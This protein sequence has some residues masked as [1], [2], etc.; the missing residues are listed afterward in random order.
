MNTKRRSFSLLLVV[1]LLLTSVV[2]ANAQGDGLTASVA[3]YL[4][5]R[6]LPD[7]KAFDYGRVDP[8]TS[9]VLLA[10]TPD[11]EWVKVQL[12]DGTTGWG[13]ANAVVADGDIADLPVVEITR[14]HAA[15][16][17]FLN[18]RDAPVIDANTVERLESGA[19]VKLVAMTDEYVYVIAE[20]GT[21]GWAVP[22]GLQFTRAPRADEPSMPELPVVNAAVDG[23]ANPRVLPDIEAASYDRLNPGTPVNVIGRNEDGDWVQIE[24][25]DGLKA[26]A[27]TRAFTLLVDL[28]DLPV[29]TPPENAAVVTNYA[30]LRA[31]PSSSAAEVATLEAGTVVTPLLVS[32]DRVFVETADG[33]QG[34]AVASALSFPGGAM[35]QML[36]ANATV[37]ADVAVNLRAEPSMD[38]LRKGAAQPGER[39]AV[40]GVSADGQWYRVVPA[41]RVAAWVFAD[42][43][44]LDAGVE[45]LPVVE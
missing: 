18:L 41:S 38:A 13:R 27:T 25:L 43:V 17:R 30:V 32:G 24:T 9:V 42:L 39:L 14:E 45:N 40:V 31:E 11:S 20:D 10:R 35:P 7:V 4:Y 23:F 5:L 21:A 22:R 16:T 2:V 28:E 15:V 26:W 36:T 29:T 34:W 3:R 1:A 44:E 8:Q 37:S 6:V 12:E 33:V 19:L